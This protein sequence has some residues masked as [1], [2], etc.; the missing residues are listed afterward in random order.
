MAG[1]KMIDPISLPWQPDEQKTLFGV[2]PSESG[3]A[4]ST[5]LA[6]DAC[7]SHAPKGW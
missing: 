5:L 2:T 6:V 7:S 1:M 3:F 4:F